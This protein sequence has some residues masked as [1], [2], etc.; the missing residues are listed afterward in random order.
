MRRRALATIIKNGKC[1]LSLMLQSWKKIKIQGMIYASNKTRRRKFLVCKVKKN[2]LNIVILLIFWFL[3]KEVHCK[4][5]V[6]NAVHL[7]PV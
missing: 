2:R 3:L 1:W 5:V 7:K 4:C 6:L